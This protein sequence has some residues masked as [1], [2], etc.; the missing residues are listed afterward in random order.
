[1]NAMICSLSFFS[2]VDNIGTIQTVLF[3]VGI[4]L[5]FAEIFSPGLGIAAVSGTI[6]L[7]AGIIMTARTP[8]EA[9]IMVLILILLIT[10]LLIIVLR[11]AKKGKLSKILILRSALS[12]EKGFSSAEDYTSLIG[13]EGI[14]LT[15]LRPSGIGEFDGKRLDVV[16]E[17]Q[18]IETG[19]K[20]SVI[21]TEGSRIVVKPN[22]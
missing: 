5:L 12:K 13:K 4:I 15:Q 19:T 1:M 18:Y 14:T 6:L 7:I 22:N 17:G 9:F 10:L 21:H 3:V 11:S 8:F 20:I 2:F 16:S